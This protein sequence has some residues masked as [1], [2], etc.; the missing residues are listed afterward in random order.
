LVCPSEGKF[1][2]YLIIEKFR[3]SLQIDSIGYH[4]PYGGSGWVISVVTSDI[5]ID[6][7]GKCPSAFYTDKHP[8]FEQII[9]DVEENILTI[10]G[11]YF[12]KNFTAKFVR[13]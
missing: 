12:E 3:I 11:K 4:S 13:Q 2:A 6:Q 5:G 9:W 10:K 1:T 7:R 8:E